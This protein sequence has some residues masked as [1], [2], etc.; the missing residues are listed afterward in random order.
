MTENKNFQVVLLGIVY[1][2]E[3]KKILIGKRENDPQIKELSWCFPGG[4]P[5]QEEDIEECL[6]KKIKLKTGYD[7]ANLG[8]VFAKTY[9]EKRDLMSIYY[10]CEVTNGEENPG[11]DLKELKWVSPEE[12]ESHFTTSFHENLKEYIMNLK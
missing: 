6:K 4:R 5:C 7:I 2:P 8:A 1:N 10:L 12:L 11:D 3:T 9:P